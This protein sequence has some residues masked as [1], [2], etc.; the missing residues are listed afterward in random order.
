MIKSREHENII[1]NDFLQ[2]MIDYQKSHNPN[3]LDEKSL[4][5]IMESFFLDAY[6]SASIALSFIC[7]QL[8][9]HPEIQEK[10]RQEVN[11]IVRKYN[12][13]LDYDALKELIYMEQVFYETFRIDPVIPVFT[14]ICT[15]RCQLRGSDGLVCQVE[16]GNIAVISSYG[17][18]TD[19]KYW[20]N[21]EKFDPER[22]NVEQISER[23][24]YI[25]LPF[26]EGPRICVGRKMAMI[27]LKVAMVQILM[28]YSLQLSKKNILPIKRDTSFSTYP[29]SG[30]WI[31]VKL[32]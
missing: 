23:S 11:T 7:F 5:V 29:K 20:Q 3:K 28:N 12:G 19:P 14:K 6:E 31:K 4:L 16:T 9:N 1:R 32:L 24:K 2:M 8:A 22:F 13:Q 26:G 27:E 10:V 18:N 15:K 25:F 17:L 30:L 21:P